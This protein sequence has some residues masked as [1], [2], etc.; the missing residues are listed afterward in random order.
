MAENHRADR[1]DGGANPN[2][3]SGFFL[4]NAW[5]P[6]HD[7]ITATQSFR[8]NCL[9]GNGNFPPLK[10]PPHFVSNRAPQGTFA[11]SRPI[12]GCPELLL[13]HRQRAMI[14][15]EFQNQTSG[16]VDGR[17]SQVDRTLENSHAESHRR[18]ADARQYF[19]AR[20]GSAYRLNGERCRCRSFT[21]FL[22]G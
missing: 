14:G 13:S 12:Q 5:H 20:A 10:N 16:R 3:N 21:L 22:S 19:R 11:T 9:I 17:R 18:Q 15:H 8:S 4:G 6:F 2:D 7:W 1:K